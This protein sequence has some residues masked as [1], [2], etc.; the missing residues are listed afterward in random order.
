MLHTFHNL[1]QLFESLADFVVAKSKHAIAKKGRF[2]FV[3]SGGSSPKH[4]YELLASDQY[5]NQ[6]EWTKVFFFFGDER[7]VPA[8]DAQSNFLM[9]KKTL[10]D[11]LGILPSQVYAIDTTVSPDD[12]ALS[13]Q[14]DIHSYFKDNPT[15]FDF[16]LLGL[17]DNVHTAS[18]FPHSAILHEQTAFVKAAFVEEVKMNRITLTAPIINKSNTIV[19]LVYG[20]SKAEAVKHVLSDA[21][22]I[23]EYPAQ[24]IHAET[25]EIHWFLDHDAAKYIKQE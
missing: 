9:A 11:P 25:G 8:S 3:L 17:G 24:L 19:F 14:N 7:Y 4:L 18:L 5:K 16:I 6:I 23:E 10:F 2:S 12:S 13:Y 15:C 22:N 21:A 1:D 20:A